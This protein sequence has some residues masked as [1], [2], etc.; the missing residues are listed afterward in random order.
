MWGAIQTSLAVIIV[1]LMAFPQLFAAAKKTQP[2]WPRQPP[3]YNG[4]GERVGGARRDKINVYDLTLV[5][6]TDETNR[7]SRAENI[8]EEVDDRSEEQAQVGEASSGRV[9]LGS[10]HRSD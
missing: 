10:G 9:G 3:F 7:S 2:T 8:M 6:T 1:S 5:T 4:L